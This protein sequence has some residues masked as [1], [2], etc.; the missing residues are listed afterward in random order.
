MAMQAQ[1]DDDSQLSEELARRGY[2]S[3][4]ITDTTRLVY[5]RQLRRL[6]SGEQP[7]AKGIII[8]LQ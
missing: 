4:P 6:S 5:Q 8:D 2:Q 1:E 7:V 3:G